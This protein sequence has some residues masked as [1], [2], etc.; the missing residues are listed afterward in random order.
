MLSE[1]KL[2]QFL[3]FWPL[4]KLINGKFSF[5][6]GVNYKPSEHVY[7]ITLTLWKCLLIS[8]NTESPSTIYFTTMLSSLDNKPLITEILIFILTI[9]SLFELNWCYCEMSNDCPVHSMSANPA[10]FRDLNVLRYQFLVRIWILV[11]SIQR[12]NEKLNIVEYFW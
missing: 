7:K 1:E 12:I 6:V 5:I 11:I 10:I 9:R 3:N 8:S 2:R 4:V